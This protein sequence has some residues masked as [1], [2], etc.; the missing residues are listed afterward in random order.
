MLPSGDLF[1][2][3]QWL[4]AGG[5]PL[6]SHNP[7]TQEVVWKGHAATAEDVQLALVAA[8]SAFP[9]WANRTLDERIR[10]L[11]AFRAELQNQEA[12]LAEAISIETGKPLWDSAT[13][14]QAMIG[15]VAISIEAYRNR[16]AEMHP[17]YPSA[18]LIA[19]HKPHG[20]I[21]VLGPFNFPGHL[22]N[23]HIIPALLAGNTIVFKP[24]E[25]T[26]RVGVAMVR[27]WEKANLPPGVLN[28]VQGGGET[29]SA[30][31][32]SAELNGLFFTGSYHTG[33]ALSKLF[34]KTPEKI[35]ALEL[36]GNNPLVVSDV[37]NIEAAVY[38]TIQSAYRTSGQRCTCARRLIL[39]ENPRA[40]E[41][42]E[43]LVTQIDSIRVG[44]F[45]D[46]PEPFMGPLISMKAV[47]TALDAQMDI[48]T[49]G[50]KAL[51]AMQQTILD[52]PFLT[53]GLMDTTKMR[54]RYDEEIFAPFLQLIRVP[55]LIAAIH[56][57]NN[58]LFGLCAGILSDKKEE[59]DLFSKYVK[60][61]VI[62]WN[63]P[64]T[65]ASSAVPFGGV[66]RSGN[67]R[68]SA[69]YAADYCS[70]P[71]ASLEADKVMMPHSLPP[72]LS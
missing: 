28:L 25:H 56:E 38:L 5:S 69:Y 29:G 14:V 18:R 70:Y 6:Q 63:T 44:P 9:E 23:G 48:W 17:S 61:G 4:R 52:L 71:V 50:G 68:P 8:Q 53:P 39:V 66:E 26:P 67:Y 65:G 55:N 13:E 31:A 41:F 60:A 34:S 59:Y 64:L 51:A 12:G 54:I 27:C 15:K 62:N 72:G 45:T 36:G 16:C 21:A 57:A 42:I 33:L 22:P 10:Y 32:E 3:N 35:L 37:E 19:R 7:A 58:T 1:I 49:R 2:A 30:L 40:E 46:I 20:V 47:K 11:E 43:R 24:S